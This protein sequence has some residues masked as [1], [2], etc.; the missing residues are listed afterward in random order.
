MFFAFRSHS[1]HCELKK[2]YLKNSM[3]YFENTHREC[4][5]AGRPLAFV[6]TNSDKK[7]LKEMFL[8]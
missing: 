1:L 2:N 3:V 7:K 5:L 8:N 6:M 4:G